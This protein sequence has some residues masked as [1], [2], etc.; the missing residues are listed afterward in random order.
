MSQCSSRRAL[1]SSSTPRE[2]AS[3]WATWKVRS[4]GSRVSTLVLVISK[5]ARVSRML[6][7]GWY[8]TPTSHCSPSLGSKLEPL[9]SIPGL[10]RKDSE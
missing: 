9:R 2:R 10:G 5:P 6:S 4:S 3:P 7:V 8:F 1:A